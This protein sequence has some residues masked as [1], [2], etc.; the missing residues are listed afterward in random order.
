VIKDL[1]L[2]VLGAVLGTATSVALPVLTKA[3]GE[4]ARSRR[5]LRWRTNMSSVACHDRLVAYYINRGKTADLY[6]CR[7]GGYEERIPFLTRPE[8]TLG[9]TFDESLVSVTSG[10]ARFETDTDLINRRRALGQTLFNAPTIFIDRISNDHGVPKL[11]LQACQYFEMLTLLGKLEEETLRYVSS[12]GRART[13]LRDR[14]WPDLATA[15]TLNAGPVSLGCHVVL[16]LRDGVGYS[17]LMQERSDATITYGGAVSSIPVYGVSP[18]PGESVTNDLLEYNLLKEY[19]EE[20][21]SYEELIDEM[22]RK[23]VD[24]RWFYSLPEIA[25]IIAASAAGDV[26]KHILGMGFDALNG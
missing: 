14:F 11:H 20:L 24:A 15:Q 26:T 5:R 9:G 10:P 2:M 8:W 22:A 21:F 4:R 16:A 7:I 18:I 1:V 17:L 19:G 13:P 6:S 12:G 3:T 25:K 23:G